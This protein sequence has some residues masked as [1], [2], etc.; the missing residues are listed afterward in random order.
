MPRNLDSFAAEW[1]RYWRSIGVDA[2]RPARIAARKVGP[3]AFDQLL[4]VIFNDPPQAWSMILA[5]IER[6]P[7]ELELGWITAGPLEDFILFHGAAFADEIAAAAAASDRLQTALEEVWGWTGMSEAHVPRGT[8]R[9]RRAASPRR[10]A[11]RI[12]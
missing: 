5:L 7:G 4:D 3:N 8:K 9:R 10:T 2:S 1:F 11:E 12:K 6:A